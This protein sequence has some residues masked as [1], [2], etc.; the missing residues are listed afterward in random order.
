MS[1]WKHRPPASG[2]LGDVNGGP[3]FTHIS[4]DDYRI[5]K[6]NV[7]GSGGTQHNRSDWCR[8][9]CSSIRSWV[10]WG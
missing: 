5:V 6:A 9:R 3:Q 7:F 10:A 1:G 8:T 4:L 2:A